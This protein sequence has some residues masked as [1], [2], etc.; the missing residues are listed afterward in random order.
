[1][2]YPN[3]PNAIG[4]D[5]R[6]NEMPIWLDDDGTQRD[7]N[8]LEIMPFKYAH[9]LTAEEMREYLET[10]KLVPVSLFWA[11]RQ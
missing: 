7:G 5:G 3:F 2:P 8:R 10:N 9:R 11:A 6:G 1:M 4:F